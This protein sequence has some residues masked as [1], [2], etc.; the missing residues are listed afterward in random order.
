MEHEPQRPDFFDKETTRSFKETFC[1]AVLL[2]ALAR[3][4]RAV[5]PRPA[6]RGRTAVRATVLLAV[7]YLTVRHDHAALL[8]QFLAQAFG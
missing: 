7:V 5:V 2:W 1:A 4:A 8:Q 3:R 6:T